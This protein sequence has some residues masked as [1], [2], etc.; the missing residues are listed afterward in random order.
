MAY[1]H[2]Y[3]ELDSNTK[4]IRIQQRAKAY[5]I[6]WDELYKTSFTWPLLHYLS[7]DEGKELL[8]QIHSGVFGGHIGARALTAKVFRQ[9]FYWPFKIGDA[10]KLVTTCQACQKFLPNTKALSQPSQLIT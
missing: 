10:S 9:G 7:R 2:Q 8:A 6:T 4:S 5:Q 3:Y 1:L